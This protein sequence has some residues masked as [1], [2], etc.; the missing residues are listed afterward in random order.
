MQELLKPLKKTAI[1]VA[2]NG[3]RPVL[4]NCIPSLTRPYTILF[5]YLYIC[6]ISSYL[7]L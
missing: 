6:N 1:T 2:A 7:K 5:L 4:I 3:D